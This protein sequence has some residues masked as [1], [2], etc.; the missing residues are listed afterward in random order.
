[1]P[2]LIRFLVIFS[3]HINLPNAYTGLTLL[4]PD[5]TI[6]KKKLKAV[7]SRARLVSELRDLIGNTPGLSCDGLGDEYMLEI[8][9]WAATDRIDKVTGL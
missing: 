4:S 3:C 9:D 5:R 6:L 7:D 8:L 2:V 1:M